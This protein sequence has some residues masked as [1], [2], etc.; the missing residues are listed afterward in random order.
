MRKW[1]RVVQGLVAS[2]CMVAAVPGVSTGQ[3]TAGELRAAALARAASKELMVV[4]RGLLA[5][6][7]AQNGPAGAIHICA[8][9]AQVVG[10]RLAAQHGLEI[11]R[12]S[13][14]WRN[15]KDEPDAFERAEL[16]RFAARLAAGVSPDSLEVSRTVT[17]D[18]AQVLRYLRPIVIGEMCLSCHGDVSKMNGPV[19]EALRAR[20][21][22]DRAVGYRAGQLRGA[23]SVKV[24]LAR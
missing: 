17:G 9:S 20:Y 14:R 8:D 13:D 5:K 4:V 21:P 15:P 16:E 12:V 6:A 10:A 23:V 2:L 3:M 7:L 19:V 11:R 18:S 1:R 22:H 24:P